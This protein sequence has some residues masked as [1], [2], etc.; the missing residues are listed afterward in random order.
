MLL[1]L[2]N[3]GWGKQIRGEGTANTASNKLKS[4]LKTAM[5]QLELWFWGDQLPGVEVKPKLFPPQA[6][7]TAW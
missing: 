7:Q 2:N 3:T 5:L 6:P 4:N 1:L